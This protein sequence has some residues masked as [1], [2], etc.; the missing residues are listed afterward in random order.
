MTM[1]KGLYRT[2][3]QRLQAFLSRLRNRLHN[4]RLHQQKD[5]QKN[6]FQEISAVAIGSIAGVLL[7]YSLCLFSAQ[8]LYYLK[9]GTWVPL[10]A[11]YLVVEPS[12]QPG[13]VQID[14]ILAT[15]HQMLT[16]F[17][18]GWFRGSESWWLRPDSWFGLHHVLWE[19]LSFLSVPGLGVVAAILLASLASG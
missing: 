11:T 19:L 14:P 12:S 7:L 8:S 5:P 6:R 3:S 9:H 2:V 15:G 10:P 13:S 16:A 1:P 4:R 17:I 18:P